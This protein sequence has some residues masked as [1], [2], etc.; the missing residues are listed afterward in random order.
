MQLTKP[1]IGYITNNLLSHWELINANLLL[2][3]V[4]TNKNTVQSLQTQAFYDYSV[5]II[6]GWWLFEPLAEVWG[7]ENK[8][9]VHKSTMFRDK[10]LSS[11]A[12]LTT[13]KTTSLSYNIFGSRKTQTKGLCTQSSTP[14]GFKPMQMMDSTFRVPE[15]LV[16]TTEP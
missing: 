15:M 4:S 7:Y 12:C 16:L 11:V 6:T 1:M 3:H 14:T 13:K 10:T 2:S 5:N 9:H 8:L